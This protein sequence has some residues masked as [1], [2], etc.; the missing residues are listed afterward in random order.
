MPKNNILLQRLPAPRR[1][2]LPNGRVFF[3]KYL[4]VVRERLP[5]QVKI[6]RT[7]VRKIGPRRQR[8]RRKNKPVGALTVT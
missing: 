3:A 1:A 5:E 6:R 4:R 7:Y 2:Q 8:C